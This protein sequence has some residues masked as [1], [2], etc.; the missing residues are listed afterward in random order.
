MGKPDTK[1]SVD[2]QETLLP[3]PLLETIEKRAHRGAIRQE[4]LPELPLELLI[5]HPIVH[6]AIEQA[7]HNNTAAIIGSTA[8]SAG[9]IGLNYHFGKSEI[10]ESLIPIYE[11]QFS[12]PS[13]PIVEAKNLP[14][15]WREAEHNRALMTSVGLTAAAL[16]YTA[17]AMAGSE[18]KWIPAA[19]SAARSA[20]SYMLSRHN[21]EQRDMKEINIARADISHAKTILEERES[22]AQQPQSAVTR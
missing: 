21:L 13:V 16:P 4:V 18:N 2:E 7:T 22:E 8:V 3:E 10:M 11:E 15:H 20:G 12:E 6:Y 9:L 19:I 1:I 14:E 17:M 5:V